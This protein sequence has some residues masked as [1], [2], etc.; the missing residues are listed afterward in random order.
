MITVAAAQL[1]LRV[2]DV[3]GNRRAGL[4]AI[5]GAAERGA[6][7]VVLSELSDTGYAFS[8]RSEALELADAE[9]TLEGWTDASAE[10]GV[11]VVGGFCESDGGSVYN[12]AAVVDRTG[13]RARY[14]K[15]HLWDREKEIFTAGHDRPPVIETSI[16]RLG[17][18]ICYDLEFPEWVRMTSA[19]GAELV[20]VPVNWPTLRRPPGER[21]I[22]VVKAQAAAASYGL[23]IVVA[24]RCNAERDTAWIG[25]SCI[26]DS[27][28]YPVAGPVLA[29]EAQ[30][31][32]ADVDTVASR[33][34]HISKRNHLL[35]DR[36][37]ALY[38]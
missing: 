1:A 22:E 7:L 10:T 17:V 38:G 28:G 19:A 11:V 15:A 14:R 24:D 16:G 29:D 18:M 5:H 3:T 30:L 2:G 6:R 31:V 21:P 26:I 27:L 8:D 36:R 25:G 32:I 33:D 20:G 4:D 35:T 9:S 12:S 13:V 34:K 23:N 37:P